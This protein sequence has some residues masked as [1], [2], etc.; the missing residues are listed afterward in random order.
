MKIKDKGLGVLAGLYFTSDYL[1]TELGRWIESLAAPIETITDV[2]FWAFVVLLIAGL[3]QK[4]RFSFLQSFITKY[5]KLSVY[6]HYIGCISLLVYIVSAVIVPLILSESVG[7]LLKECLAW[8]LIVLGY[9]GEI[10][11]LVIATYK[12]FFQPK[13]SENQ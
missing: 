13:T 2:M 9:G 10:L 8:V 6:M 11:A 7:S 5:P 4:E 3:I 12:V 1:L